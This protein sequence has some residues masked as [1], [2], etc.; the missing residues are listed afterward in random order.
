MGRVDIT[1]TLGKALGGAMA[2]ILPLKKELSNCYVNVPD[3]ICF[4]ILAPAI[5]GASIK[6]LNY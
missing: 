2:V 3:L 6:V 5:V 4:S 1:G